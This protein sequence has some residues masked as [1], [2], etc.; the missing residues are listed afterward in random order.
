MITKADLPASWSGSSS[1]ATVDT[2]S[3]LFEV[4]SGVEACLKIGDIRLSN[5]LLSDVFEMETSSGAGSGGSLAVPSLH[6]VGL[7]SDTLS[8][9]SAQDAVKVVRAL[10]STLGAK[11]L[12][13]PTS[14]AGGHA[15]LPGTISPVS[16]PK[17]GE[18]SAALGLSLSRPAGT[19][20]TGSASTPPLPLDLPPVSGLL[21][22]TASGDHVVIVFAEGIGEPA[23]TAVVAAAL[24][25]L[26]R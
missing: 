10:G 8:A 15:A 25:K 12:G 5:P 2:N 21:A 16:F 17:V 6:V 26:G 9:P 19:S 18:A 11:C 22:L 13:T 24:A 14:T 3:K 20:S 1:G 7:Q 4:V 23:P